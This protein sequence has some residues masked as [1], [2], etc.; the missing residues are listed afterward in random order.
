[1][2]KRDIGTGVLKF[3]GLFVDDDDTFAAFFGYT[4]SDF[5]ISPPTYIA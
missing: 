4:K 1:M 2:L 3:Q 5:D